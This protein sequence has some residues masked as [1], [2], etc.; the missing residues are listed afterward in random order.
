[1]YNN[2]ICPREKT[3]KILPD[4]MKNKKTLFFIR[5]PEEITY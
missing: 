4:S 2:S 5:I 1:L 3:G